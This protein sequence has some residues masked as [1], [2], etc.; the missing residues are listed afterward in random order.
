MSWVTFTDPEVAAFG[1]S[2]IELKNRKRAY[3]KIETGFEEDDRAVT[4]NYRYG[5]LIFYLSKPALLAK[6]KILG[7]AM[8]APNAGE[9]IQELILA[10]TNGM[11]INA[12][13]NKIYPYPVASRINQR[14]IVEYKSMGLTDTVKKLLKIA[15]KIFS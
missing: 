3:V 12:I 13:F 7:G 8:V 14:A 5:K 10:N 2:E 4:D 11:S 1:L 9:L 6:Q 15:F